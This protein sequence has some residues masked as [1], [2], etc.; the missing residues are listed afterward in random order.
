MKF[1]RGLFFFFLSLNAAAQPKF[2]IQEFTGVVKSFSPGMRFALEYL[3]L[4]VNGKH[5]T[6]A[7]YPHHGAFLYDHIKPGDQIS[8]RVNIN[9]RDRSI[10]E[11]FNDEKKSM[12]YFL[13]NDRI[14][15]VKLNNE[16]I[17]FPESKVG[18]ENQIR[19]I[20]IEK[21]VTGEYS[22]RGM[23]RGLM[24]ENGCW[25]YAPLPYAQFNTMISIAPGDIVSFDGWKISDQKGY[26]YPVS[27][28]NEIF[29]FNP[30][31]KERGN[32]FSFL[33]KQNSVCIGVKFRTDAGKE[34]SVSFP[35]DQA[36]RVK[37]FI[38][39]DKKI[40]IYYH[41]FKVEGQLHP[42]EMQ[43]L[44]QGVD[45]LYIDAFGFYGGADVKHDHK[46]VTI[47]GKIT[48]INTSERGNVLSVIVASE[49]YIEIDAMMAQQLG[50]FFQKGKEVSISGK[51]RIR[52][53]GEI[54]QKDYRIVTP[55]KV[56]VDGKTFLLYN[57]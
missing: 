2:E 16:W 4:D 7:F 41:N 53:E 47:D 8:I 21:K 37:N 10:R 36:K 55:E 38:K 9:L 40:T 31:S 6:F 15:E 5:E 17:A 43:A 20:F 26:K 34:L 1:I 30:L 28:V 3:E 13:F 44:I 12:A 50:Y 29:S 45:T 54:Y 24:F 22:Y 49:Y 57:P 32:L 14:T 33:Y 42:P 23:R 51:E 48:K 35:S 27:Q 25:A 52:K 18:E 46:E 39:P 11:K 56:V 19:K